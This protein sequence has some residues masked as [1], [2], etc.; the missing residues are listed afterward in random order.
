MLNQPNFFYSQPSALPKDAPTKCYLSTT[1]D[2]G[3]MKS[4]LAPTQSSTSCVYLITKIGN[5][6]LK[7]EVPLYKYL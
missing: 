5:R 6:N 4:S 1:F 2:L 3:F 7:I